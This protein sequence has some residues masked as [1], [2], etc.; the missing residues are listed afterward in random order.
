[1]KWF[2]I[3]QPLLWFTLYPP[4]LYAPSLYAF[5]TGK[6]IR[7]IYGVRFWYKIFSLKGKMPKAV[8]S[9]VVYKLNCAGCT[10]SYIG[11]TTPYLTLSY[12]ILPYLTYR[13]YNTLSYLILPYLTYRVYN[14][15]SYLILPYLTLSYI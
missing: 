4:S 9:H 12:P 6:M 3:D 15:L 7:F 1:M 14:T 2:V 10:A 11:Y 13:V 8:R 5:C